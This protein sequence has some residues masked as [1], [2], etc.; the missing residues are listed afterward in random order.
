MGAD[1]ITSD[2]FTEQTIAWINDVARYPLFLFAFSFASMALAAWLGAWVGG[3]RRIDAEGREQFAVVRTA[4]LTLLAL[5][6][7]F[8][9]SMAL[10]R[11]DQRKNDEAAEA[12]AIGTEYIRADLLPAG[13]AAKVRALLLAYVDQ[14][15]AFYSIHDAAR[16][17]EVDKETA[18]LQ[19]ELWS[20]VRA[21]ANAQPTAMI[22]LAVAG[23]ND[24]L[25]SESRTRAA[26]L[27]R[28]PVG[29]WGLLLAVAFC[30]NAL[31]GLGARF[32]KSDVVVVLV[33]PIV[34]AIALYLIADIDSPRRGSIHVN[35]QNLLALARSLR[36]Q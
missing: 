7:G 13:E 10:G 6:I 32:V 25:N 22:A 21:P 24:V 18:R 15:V 31:V 14:R 8:T 17:R 16:L 33:I 11:Y 30:A 26:W 5:I 9:F 1:S 19:S 29:A 23:M 12:N 28:I 20:A 36:A 34:V 2:P 35:P 3:A 27:N 4:T